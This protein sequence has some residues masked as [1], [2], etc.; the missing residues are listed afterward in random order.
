M[1][2]EKK[3]F[4]K[5]I[6]V[7]GV[8]F[9]V[10]LVLSFVMSWVILIAV[11]RQT[12]GRAKDGKNEK[13]QEDGTEEKFAGI[14]EDL[15]RI[16]IEDHSPYG[17]DPAVR[18]W[19]YTRYEY[20]GQGNLIG[21]Y[22]YDK[23]GELNSY[24][25][26][27]YDDRGRQVSSIEDSIYADEEE[28]HLYSYDEEDRLLHTE[29]W[30]HNKLHTY[31]YRYEDGLVICVS[32]DYDENGEIAGQ[33]VNAEKENGDEV[34]FGDYN[35]DGRRE[36]YEYT[37]YDEQGRQ[38]Y[39]MYG[40][41]IGTTPTYKRIYSEWVQI[42]GEDTCMEISN[43][44][45]ELPAPLGETINGVWLLDKNVYDEKG[46]QILRETSGLKNSNYTSRYY[47]DYDGELL[48][49]EMQYSYGKELNNYRWN[50][51]EGDRKD[52]T[53]AIDKE[54]SERCTVELFRREYDEE[55]RLTGIY[56][57]SVKDTMYLTDGQGRQL[58]LLFSE[59]GKLTEI[60]K[61][62]SSEGIKLEKKPCFEDGKF[63]G[64]MF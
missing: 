46:N 47:A 50:T 36:R 41:E 3:T 19:K 2:G 24:D 9:A 15:R 35:V 52:L 39:R 18:L 32:T 34:L 30:Y 11:D 7:A 56:R 1:S 25:I 13:T 45:G 58:D 37:Q 27:T 55:G 51:Y 57:Y 22:V 4:G 64:M 49:E 26:R 5:A 31:D 42:E 10:F 14:S 61:G 29:W 8:L 53:V 48:L 6:A 43:Q 16:V 59:E 62:I 33:S 21:I 44:T 23:E 40:N 63:V 12:G 17:D 20:D 38:I 60:R 28:Y 54:S